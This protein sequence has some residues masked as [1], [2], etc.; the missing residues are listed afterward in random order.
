MGCIRPTDVT[1]SPSVCY[2]CAVARKSTSAMAK[3]PLFVVP[4]DFSQDME[5]T[6][7]AAFALARRYG[8]EV[9]LLEVVSPRGAAILGDARAHGSVPKATGLD[10]STRY[11]LRPMR[12]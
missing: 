11:R 4:V 9:H 2:R 12:R 5:G 7:S 3:S 8:A 1:R 10:W 6:V